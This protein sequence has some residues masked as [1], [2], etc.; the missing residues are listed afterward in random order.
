[1]D[2]AASDRE[3]SYSLNSINNHTIKPASNTKM[4]N[5]YLLFAS[6]KGV[7]NTCDMYKQKAEVNAKT[8]PPQKNG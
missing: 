5:A 7:D 2:D 8:R 1:M 3:K 4:E 6:M